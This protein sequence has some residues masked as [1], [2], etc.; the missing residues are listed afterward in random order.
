[1]LAIR[2]DQQIIAVL[3]PAR[4][5]ALL[6]PLLASI[7]ALVQAVDTYYKSYHQVFGRRRRGKKKK[8]EKAADWR[9]ADN[10]DLV[11]PSLLSFSDPFCTSS[12]NVDSPSSSSGCFSSTLS[13]SA[14]SRT[15]RW[16][17]HTQSAAMSRLGWPAARTT[18]SLAGETSCKRSST[19]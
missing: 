10:H 16:R 14:A 19:E 12:A 13:L 18:K 7:D 17:W 15:Q 5:R 6:P 2:R 4:R 11:S 8:P 9:Y 3:G 1:M